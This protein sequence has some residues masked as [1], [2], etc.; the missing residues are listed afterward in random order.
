MAEEREVVLMW[1]LRCGD[2]GNPYLAS[3]IQLQLRISR[4]RHGKVAADAFAI[5]AGE[6]SRRLAAADACQSIIRAVILHSGNAH[7]ERFA[8]EKRRSRHIGEYYLRHLTIYM[9]IDKEFCVGTSSPNARHVG[10]L[11]IIQEVHFTNF[12]ISVL[13]NNDGP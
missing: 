13:S 1:L 4:K 3:R 12:G 10:N 11:N 2:V 7:R 5:G 9:W 6:R 8:A